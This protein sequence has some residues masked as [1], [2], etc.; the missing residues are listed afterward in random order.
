MARAL[1]IGA[2]VAAAFWVYSIVDCAV[3]HPTRHRGVGKPAWIA[4]VVLLPVI[5]GI[6]WFVVGRARASKLQ[7]PRA[8]DDDPE[9]LGTIGSI[10]DQ[11]E[12]IRRLEE[13]LALLDAE[14][15]FGP[16]G[17]ATPPISSAGTGAAEPP[18]RSNDPD[19]DGRGQRG[20]HG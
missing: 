19:D 1:V 16:D 10:S 6:L 18:T 20:A 5:G 4:I 15:D 13:E 3:Q 14:D 9:F 8:P 11:D 12:R 17:P 7:V 2:L